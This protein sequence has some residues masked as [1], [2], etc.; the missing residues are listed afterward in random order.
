MSGLPHHSVASKLLAEGGDVLPC[1]RW[2]GGDLVRRG[3]EWGAGGAIT[4]VG[5]AMVFGLVVLALILALGRVSGAHINPAVTIAFVLRR[6][7][8]VRLAVAY[9][10]AQITGALAASAV[11]RVLVD[12]D[13]TLLDTTHLGATLPSGEAWL[14]LVLEGV[15]TFIQMLVILGS[16]SRGAPLLNVAIAVGATVGLEALFAGPI[17]GASMNPARSIGPAVVGGHL[18]HLWMYVVAPVVGSIGAVGV[19]HVIEPR[20]ETHA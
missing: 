15:L 16:G 10:I 6:A 8:G 12:H 19:W 13:A 4:H 5:V 2:D 17:C 14:S 9:V 20:S 1:H 18:E 11:L 3:V 7:I